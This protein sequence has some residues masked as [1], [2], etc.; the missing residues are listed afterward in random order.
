MRFCERQTGHETE[1]EYA[2]PLYF[3][4][5]IHKHTMNTKYTLLI[6]Y[7]IQLST[8]SDKLSGIIILSVAW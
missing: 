3:Q 7:L 5:E 4:M 1:Q 2:I 8:L 6:I